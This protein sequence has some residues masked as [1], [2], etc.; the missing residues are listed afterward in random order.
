MLALYDETN[1]RCCEVITKAYSTSFSLGILTLDKH[2]RYPI[3]AI[4][5]YVRYADEIVDTFHTFNKKQLL[6]E[7][8]AET[9]KAIQA[10]ISLNPIIHAFQKVVNEYHI[11]LELIDAFLKS[12]EMDLE[13]KRYEESTYQEYIYGSAEV[14]GLMCL[15]VFCHDNE[16]LYHR[17][18]EHARS[19]GA[20][21]QKVNFLRDMRS[22]YLE[23]G[24]IYFPSVNFSTFNNEAKKQIEDN[25]QRDFDHAL[26][27]IKQLPKSSRRGVYLAYRY[28]MTLFNKIKK[29]HSELVKQERIRVSDVKKMRILFNTFVKS[30]LNLL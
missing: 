5:G 20:A 16:P 28:Y 27:G 19:L 29:A 6:D 25:I 3:Y 2:L 18:K 4:Y 17:L 14:V 21:F 9:Y 24:R 10:G 1:Y 13:G 12:M 11:P 8:R 23:R 7:Y 22:D 30:S 26:E 15:K